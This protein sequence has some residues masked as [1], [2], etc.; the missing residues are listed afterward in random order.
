MR[1]FT[2]ELKNY[3]KKYKDRY[4]DETPITYSKEEREMFQDLMHYWGEQLR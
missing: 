2:E 4:K 3:R 1:N